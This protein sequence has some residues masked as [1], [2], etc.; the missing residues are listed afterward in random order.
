MAPDR[1]PQFGHL[2]HLSRIPGIEKQPFAEMMELARF[3]IGSLA[4]SLAERGKLSR[5]IH[6]ALRIGASTARRIGLNDLAFILSDRDE[7]PGYDESPCLSIG[8]G[9]QNVSFPTSPPA[10]NLDSVCL[11]ELEYLEALGYIRGASAGI[12]FAH[13]DYYEVSSRVLAAGSEITLS[14]R[15]AILDRGLSSLNETV[16]KS[17]A[18]TLPLFYRSVGDSDNARHLV[19]EVGERAMRSIFPGVR[20]LALEAIIDWLPTLTPDDRKSGMALIADDDGYSYQEIKWEDD[21]PWTSLDRSWEDL[22]ARPEIPNPSELETRLNLIASG[23][24]QR[25][26]RPREAWDLVHFIESNLDLPRTSEVLTELLKQSHAFIRAKAIALLIRKEIGRP[27]AF[28]QPLEDERNPSVIRAAIS[29]CLHS[30]QHAED[31]VRLIIR[32]WLLQAFGRVTTAV[33]CSRLLV[34]F[35]DPYSSGTPNYEKLGETDRQSLWLLWADLIQIYLRTVADQPFSHNGAHMYHSLQSA[36]EQIDGVVFQGVVES[37]VDWIVGQLGMRILD[38]YE[39][40]AAEL[41]LTKVE[42]GERRERLIYGM[43]NHRDTGFAITTVNF[44]VKHWKVLSVPEETLLLDVLVS[45]RI[46]ARWLRATAITRDEVPPKIQSLLLSQDDLLSQGA[47]SVLENCPPEILSDAIH[48]FCGE[49]QP[50]WWFGLHHQGKE[51]WQPILEAILV[52]ST[53]PKLDV[54]LDEML[55][56]VLN[57]SSAVWRDPLGS[58]RILCQSGDALL[59]RRLFDHLL[60]A[61]VKINGPQVYGF[62]DILVD[63]AAGDDEVEFFTGGIMTNLNAISKNIDNPREFFG[64]YVFGALLVPKLQEEM[65]FLRACEKIRD[66]LS[67]NE[68]QEG[69]NQLK[70]VLRESPPRLFNLYRRIEVVL[71]GCGSLTPEEVSQIASDARGK[72]LEH[73]RKQADSLEKKEKIWDWVFGCEK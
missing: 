52:D 7:R 23:K 68:E 61:S 65:R 27:E 64:E 17:S 49:P 6:T 16:A 36:C 38:D 28:L 10:T 24:S 43:L 67:D 57:S 60:R 8:G 66:H 30:W 33:V 55:R 62:W 50:L 70:A 42:P 37:W 71:N 20:D 21:I 18:L 35:G 9:S 72:F 26:I 45:E 73:A 34:D 15:L 53:H 3:D 54:V 41:L 32:D 63:S 51:T 4:Q 5:N 48:L 13:P 44:M 69:I 46:D 22:Y 14:E 56:F 29:Q 40:A 19:F 2:L 59:R 11:E 47:A 25:G 39:L 1:L 12:E 31:H 58:W